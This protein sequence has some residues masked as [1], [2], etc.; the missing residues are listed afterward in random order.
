MPA[1]QPPIDDDFAPASGWLAHGG[2]PPLEATQK[3]T[4]EHDGAVVAALYRAAVGGQQWRETL[5]KVGEVR[6]LREEVGPDV[7]AARKWL[8]ARAP[9]TWGAKPAQEVRVIVARIEGRETVGV[10]LEHDAGVTIGR[11]GD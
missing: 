6:V 7:A 5:D 10:T 1:V 4:T 8:E 2:T 11:Q 9:D 3:P